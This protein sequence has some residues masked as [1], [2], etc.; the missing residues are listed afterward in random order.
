MK[1]KTCILLAALSALWLFLSGCTDKTAGQVFRLDILSEPSSLDPQIATSDEQYLI[2][3]NSMEGLLRLDESQKPVK[4]AASDYTVSPDGLTYTFTLRKG[5]LWSDGKTPVTA[6]D[7][8]F[9]FRRLFNPETQSPTASHFTCI[10][11]GAAALSGEGSIQHIGVFAQDAYTLVFTLESANP[12]FLSLLTT[13]AALPCNEDFFLASRGKYGVS[14]EFMLFNGPFFIYNWAEGEYIHL[15]KNPSYHAEETVIPSAFRLY[16]KNSYELSRLLDGA[17]DAAAVSFSDLEKLD[18]S[19]QTVQFSNILWS[20][21][22]NLEHPALANLSIRQALAASIQREELS[23]YL[24]ENQQTAE[25]PVPPAVTLGG[26]SYRQQAS[27]AAVSSEPGYT[28]AEL[29][30]IGLKELEL[31]GAPSL[32][33]LCPEWDGIPLLLSY[34]QRQWRDALGVF[35]NI[36]PV[37][38]ETFSRRLASRDYDLVF[39]P[40]TA[41]YDSPQAVLSQLCGE[42]SLTGWQ[43]DRMAAFF[44]QA[45]NAATN[46]GVLSAY[47]SAERELIQ[48]GIVLPVFYETSYY[49]TAPSVTGLRF[50]PFGCRVY[51]SEG[52]KKDG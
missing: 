24:R 39:C 50:S 18:E 45:E 52:R 27:G 33:L 37:D 13:P 29:F 43:N 31:E 2:L 22:P 44:S 38:S 16:I 7:F 12:S 4:A 42:G 15:R 40:V 26:E 23:A 21:L 11:G 47:R 6:H 41:S 36:D 14:D 19:Y 28:A 10:R 34:L 5:M 48:N 46:G 1:K 17:V 9:A 20:V 49:A 8:Q 25:M 30:Q 32:T 51:F 3:L 35:I